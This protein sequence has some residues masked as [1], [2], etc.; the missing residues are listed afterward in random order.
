MGVAVSATG[1]YGSWST[2]G[3]WSDGTSTTK[4]W[5]DGSSGSY[6]SYREQV[7]YGTYQCYV[8]GTY[9][10]SAYQSGP[11]TTTGG[12]T[13][14]NASSMPR[15]GYSTPEDVGI[16]QRT[17]TS[18]YSWSM[19]GGVLISGIIGINLSVSEGYSG[20]HMME[21]SFST[22]DNHLCG[23]NTYPSNASDVTD[24]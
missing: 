11:I 16:W 13:L 18:G 9:A 15:Y 23:N 12:F 14:A 22:N 24:C 19:S 3:T 10:W 4:V 1:A 21:Y 7:E 8:V 2:S 20:S 5:A 17:S 6:A